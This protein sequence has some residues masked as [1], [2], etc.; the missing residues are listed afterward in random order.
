[1]L[2]AIFLKL[3]FGL[4]LREI[5]QNVRFIA[6]CHFVFHPTENAK[7]FKAFKPARG[8]ST[9]PQGKRIQ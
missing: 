8:G 1:M 9:I 3:A 2:K 7:K 5:L 6:F 4:G